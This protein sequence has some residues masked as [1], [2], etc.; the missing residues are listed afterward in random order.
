MAKI[1]TDL[2]NS[3]KA[4]DTERLNVLRDIIAETNKASKTSSPIHTD[5][6]LLSLIRKRMSSAKEAA[7]VFADAKRNDLKEKEEA[8]L[9]ILEEYAGQV[10]TM[11][12]KDIQK[13]ISQAID[14][15]KSQDHKVEVGSVLKSLFAPGGLLDGKPVERSQVAKIAK[16]A[17]S[18]L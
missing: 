16:D 5:V 18:E 2:K 17:V 10:Q 6:Q 8:Q 12:I 15:I 13:S 3:M 7:K 11:S 14:Q 4:K 1:R 9:V